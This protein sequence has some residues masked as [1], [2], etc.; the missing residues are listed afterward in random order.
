M[1]P[2]ESP[3]IVRSESRHLWVGRP[4][5]SAGDQSVD[6]RWVCTTHGQPAPAT[7]TSLSGD[8]AANH[9]PSP[10]PG[11]QSPVRSPEGKRR[12]VSSLS[13]RLDRLHVRSAAK[14][15]VE[16]EDDYSSRRFIMT[17]GYAKAIASC[18]AGRE[19]VQMMLLH[20]RRDA[21]RVLAP[22]RVGGLGDDCGASRSAPVVSVSCSAGP[23]KTSRRRMPNGRYTGGTVSAGAT[24]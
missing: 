19:C 7:P 23:G 14:R 22:G 1:A 2:L 15:D 24:A 18:R 5:P 12:T 11:G 10:S 3:A 16:E 6:E 20:V 13:R 9:S 4:V 8:P 17:G 21:N